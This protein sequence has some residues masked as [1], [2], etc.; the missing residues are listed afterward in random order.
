M[1][2]SEK[3]QKSPPKR[4][5]FCDYSYL[6]ILLRFFFSRQPESPRSNTYAYQ[7]SQYPYVHRFTSILLVSSMQFAKKQTA[8]TIPKTRLWKSPT[9]NGLAFSSQSAIL[10]KHHSLSFPMRQTTTRIYVQSWCRR[11]DSNSHG[12]EPTRP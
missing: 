3:K 8:T 9:A 1:T 2:F 4:G 7:E 6:V 11:G 12:C 5:L 10:F